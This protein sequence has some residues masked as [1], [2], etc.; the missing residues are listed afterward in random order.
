MLKV[1]NVIK[2]V[3]MLNIIYVLNFLNLPTFVMDVQQ[4]VDAGVQ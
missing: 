4:K 2:H 1:L 3:K